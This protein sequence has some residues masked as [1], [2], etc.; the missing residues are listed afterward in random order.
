MHNAARMGD[1]ITRGETLDTESRKFAGEPRVAGSNTRDFF[2]LGTETGPGYVL[3]KAHTLDSVL[4]IARYRC[5][6]IARAFV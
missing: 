3:C 2:V 4:S 1:C 6:A 5:N